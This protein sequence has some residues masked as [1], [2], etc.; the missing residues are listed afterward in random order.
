MTANPFDNGKPLAKGIPLD[1][2]E[3]S[4]QLRVMTAYSEAPAAIYAAALA[5]ISARIRPGILT[6]V[7]EQPNLH[8]ALRGERGSGKGSVWKHAYAL[9]NPALPKVFDGSSWVDTMETLRFSNDHG[10]LF[11]LERRE[12]YNQLLRRGAPGRDKFLA[13][14]SGETIERR[15]GGT[16]E[17]GTYR[18]VVHAETSPYVDGWLF[19]PHAVETGLTT[20]FLFALVSRYGDDARRNPEWIERAI[21]M[22]RSTEI[23]LPD[24]SSVPDGSLPCPRAAKDAYAQFFADDTPMFDKRMIGLRFKVALCHAALHGRA[25]VT[26][27]DWKW[28]AYPMEL[29]RSIC[30]H[31]F[32]VA[33]REWRWDTGKSP[34]RHRITPIRKEPRR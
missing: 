15:R 30:A 31:E 12:L 14:W 27:N 29:S 21:E 11:E 16:L 17:A 2:F 26:D 6:P 19:T 13:L 7:G 22:R 5:N 10:V 23:D 32:E 4:P 25:E 33:Q 18:C 1:A 34:V 20:R 28:S 9:V 24:W 3:A 8:V